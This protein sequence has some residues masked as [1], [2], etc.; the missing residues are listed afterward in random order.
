[1]NLRFVILIIILQ[2]V[3][4]QLLGQD[5][6]TY[7]SKQLNAFYKEG[8]LKESDSVF[9][10][11]IAYLQKQ[12][13]LE[14][15]LYAYWD[16]FMLN[17]SR[18]RIGLI[19]NIDSKIKRK[20]STHNEHLSK[21]HLWINQGYYLKKYG[22][23]YQ[24]IISYE[25]ALNYFDKHK[26]NY[27]ILDYCL[28]PLA[29]NC[30]R[31]GDYQ[32]AD[33]L[34]I[35]S[36]Q[37][38]TTTKNSKQIIAFA[39]NLAISKHSQGDYNLA[40]EIL[41]KALLTASISEIQ[42]SRI[43]SELARNWY[44]K[45]EYHQAIKEVEKSIFYQKKLQN[46]NQP[47]LIN[48]Y[49][50]KGLCF[51]ALN[52]IEKAKNEIDKALSLAL[53]T[54]ENRGR[55][56][57]KLYLLLAEIA[58]L[59]LNYREAL[60][61][62]QKSLQI[63]LPEYK[64]SDTFDNPKPELFYPE[65]T[66]KE[67]L[68]ARA[69]I[70]TLQKD[71]KNALKNYDL[72]FA[73]EELLRP[74]YSSQKSKIIQQTENRNRSIH[75]IDLCHKLY[76]QTADNQYILKAFNYAEQSKSLVLLDEFQ[77]KKNANLFQSDS[78]WLLQKELQFQKAVLSKEIQLAIHQR[79]SQDLIA[80]SISKRSKLT[81][82]LQIIKHEIQKKHSF[83]RFYNEVSLSSIQNEILINDKILIEYF[84]GD[85]FTT[86]FKI[87]ATG[88]SWRKIEND[89]YFS[90][91][92][93]FFTFF[94]DDTGSKITNDVD[95]YKKKALA[96]YQILLAEELKKVET[97]KLLII[98]DGILSF[99]PFDA[100]LTAESKSRKFHDM[101]FLIKE[102]E[103]SYGYSVSILSQK[104]LPRTLT[105]KIAGFFPEFTDNQRGLSELP[106]T[107]E[108]K[109]KIEAH[110]PIEIFERKKATKENFIKKAQKAHIIHLSTHANTK[111]GNKLS[112]I[113][114][115]DEPL[116]LTEL[117]G[118]QIQ[119]D[120][121]VLSACETGIGQVQKGEGAMSLAR[122][123]SYAGVSNLVVSLWKVNDKATSILMGDFYSF[124]SK[125][126]TATEALYES[127]LSYLN[128]KDISNTKKSPYY[129][130]SFIPIENTSEAFIMD[131]STN[132]WCF[133]L[134]FFIVVGLFIW[135][136]LKRGER[137]NHK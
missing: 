5:S 124:L 28:K 55:E 96:I 56:V 71:Y 22:N 17:P 63:L 121:V 53:V 64:P 87:D 50:T 134:V 25:K 4:L 115:W 106:F 13:N 26:L 62:H 117:Y 127:K 105:K 46:K 52:E 118:Y 49:T 7:Y 38:A 131:S 29:N 15:E 111:N 81:N 74:T 99:I 19:T 122:G 61:M 33:D 45:Q 77:N 76:E 100:L 51:I 109:R 44:K 27:N 16:F 132:Y 128:N 129:W 98:P 43:H 47:I 123:F 90:L 8:L 39:N 68:D 82:K 89:K 95:N 72:S 69:K 126:R 110:F 30:T 88:L 70:F 32:R 102:Q 133:Y 42:K 79:V 23:I 67:A 91:L 20:P 59:K 35:R 86:I 37:L 1:M 14:E 21:M 2:L 75:V 108:E 113:E 136:K 94:S 40:I 10:K 31:I 3:S 83:K 36:L 97:Q 9:K 78:L 119:A 137:T 114:F 54:Y 107:Q 48:S 80:K 34:M 57:A 73:Q 125:N 65:N 58:T 60:T 93:E 6:L 104:Q 18:K 84:I 103:I 92:A 101:P 24:S 135:F 11:K 116:Y 66:I 41:N 120:L 12:D 130:A 112:A 85:T